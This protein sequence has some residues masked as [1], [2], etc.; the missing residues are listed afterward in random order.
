[1]TLEEAFKKSNDTHPDWATYLHLCEIFAESG[2]ETKEIM[3][4]FIYYMPVE[5]YD[6]DETDE[7]VAYLVKIS[8]EIPE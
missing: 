5:E 2:A 3:Q 4:A 6:K 8:T 1:M 7:M